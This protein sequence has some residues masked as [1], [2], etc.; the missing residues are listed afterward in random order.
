MIGRVLALAVGLLG[1]LAASQAPEFAQQYRQRLGGAIDEMRRV[2][3]RFDEN[4]KVEGTDREG[5]V[6]RLADSGD[7]LVRRQADATREVATRLARLEQQ[8]QSFA[9]AGPFGR[10]LVFA[11][12]ADPGLVR[13]TYLDYEPAWPATSEGMVTGGAGFL[14]G[15]AGL[16]FLGR[17]GRRLTPRRRSTGTG[18]L[19]SA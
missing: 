7:P 3:E 2:L 5:A 13:A 17:V 18:R 8:R 10:L 15:W 4:A 14:A 11:R 12:D 9:E 6:K 16:L 1:G 19:R